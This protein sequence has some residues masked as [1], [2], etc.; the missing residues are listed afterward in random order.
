M[1]KR[2]AAMLKK[3]VFQIYCVFVFVFGYFYSVH[4]SPP[5]PHNLS[6]TQANKILVTV[7]PD[8]VLLKQN[9]QLYNSSL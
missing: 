6:S 9:S 8:A 3:K 4:Y 2:T 1:N 5:T 7:V